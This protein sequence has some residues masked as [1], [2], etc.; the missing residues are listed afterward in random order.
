MDVD[1]D[2]K[3][4]SDRKTLSTKADLISFAY[5]VGMAIAIPLVIFALGGRFLDKAYGTTPL[6]L[7]FGLLLSLVSTSYIIYKKVKKFIN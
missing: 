6:Y 3:E 1:D 7:I 5:E 2:Q 4:V